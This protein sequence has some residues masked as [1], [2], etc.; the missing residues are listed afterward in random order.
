MVPSSFHPLIR[1]WFAGVYGTPTAI[2]A[3]AWPLIE[4]GEH[5]LAL[6]PTGSGKTLTAFLSAL[7]RF[8]NGRYAADQ[9]GV[10]YV[11]PLKALNEDIRRNLLE[12]IAGIRSR[13]EAAG[14]SFPAI[15]VETRSGDTPQA[16]RRR[17][18]LHPP[19]ILAATP[20]SLAILLLNPR[21]RAVLSSVKY[22]ILDEI[23]TA[24]GTKRGSF[25]SC[26]VDRLALAAGEFQRVALSATV[27]GGESAATLT[28]GLRPLAGG[29]FEGRPVRIAAPASEKRCELTVDFPPDLPASPESDEAGSFSRRYDVLA[30]YIIGRINGSRKTDGDSGVSRPFSTTLVF[31]DSRRRAE[32]LALLLNGKAGCRIAFAHHGSLSRELR[33]DVERRLAE[34]SLPCVV[35]TSSLELGI[36]IG[37]VDEVILAGSPSSASAALQRVGRSGHGAG[38]VSRGVLIP[39]HG[40][41]LLLA[42]ALSLAVHEKEIE[43]PRPVENPLDV[44]AQ[45]VLALCAEKERDAGELYHTVRGFYVFRNLS[46]SSFDSVLRMLAGQGGKKAGGSFIPLRELKPRL[47]LDRLSG[48]LTPAPGLLPL[49]FTSGGVITGRGNYSLRIPGGGGAMIKIGELDEEFVWERRVGDCFDF[50]SRSWRITAIGS[51]AVEALPRSEAANQ[52]P[53]WRAE[54][55]FRSPVLT[56]RLLA[57]LDAYNRTVELPGLPGFSAAAV[58]SLKAYLDSQKAA[59][60]GVPL[61]G[62][63]SIVIEIVSDKPAGRSAA[64]FSD[65]ALCTVLLHT[66]RGSAVN[67]PLRL[68]LAEDLEHT[69]SRRLESF[70]DDNALLLLMP[71][72][73]GPET[74]IRESLA[75]MSESGGAVTRGETLL[76]KRL[77]SSGLFGA[78]FRE[79]AERSLVLPRSPL[80]RR[81]PLWITRQK[82]KRLFDAAA[83]EDDFPVSAEAWR[84][85]LV[86]LFD[87]EAFRNLIDELA[88]GS[89][90]IRC[91]ESSRP[92]PFARDLVRQETNALIYEDDERKDRGGTGGTPSLSD[93]AIAEALGDPSLRPRLASSLVRDFTARLRRELNGWTAEDENGLAEWVK[94]R[95]AIPLDEW[96]LLLAAL[97]PELARTAASDPSL[98][99][100]LLRIERSS[101]EGPAAL[102]IHREWEAAW[103]EEAL[104]LLG[105]WLRY[106]GPL[107]LSRIAAVFGVS[108]AEAEDAVD[109]LV[110]AEAAAR[111]IAV[112]GAEPHVF[113]GDDLAGDRE[114][115][116]LLLRLSR[117]KARPRPRERPAALLVPFLALRQGLCVRETAEQSG[118]TNKPWKAL[119]GFSAPVRLWESEIFPSRFSGYTPR[120]LDGELRDG[121]CVFYGTGKERAAFCAPD[122]LDLVSTGGARDEVFAGISDRH[123]FDR[124]RDFWEIKE[125]LAASS[126]VSDNRTA[127]ASLWE[128]VWEGRLSADSWEALR[129]GAVH[130]F[131]PDEAEE[132]RAPDGSAPPGYPFGQTRRRIPRALRNRWKEGAPVRGNWFSLTGDYPPDESPLDAEELNRGR[133]RLLIERWGILCGP[134]LER[135]APLL[136][137]ARLLPT[138]RRMELAGELAA[139]R[140]FG[141]IN[142]LQFAP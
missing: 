140:F 59:Q 5:V 102:I 13:F 132:T 103:R 83:K 38:R 136:S 139:G 111:H 3:S 94:E 43:A 79:A 96:E 119:A 118:E 56:R 65:G 52:V 109:A 110:E 76:R 37:G 85:C 98:G 20:E 11:S 92:S 90:S 16:E 55:P 22:V 66:F 131:V 97:P 62:S 121:S 41:D 7:S 64:A 129:R 108:E 112:S 30:A 50:G 26:Q 25:L 68:A 142:S 1:E 114:N 27:S 53:F 15:R 29:S 54:S 130:G 8:A 36:D 44:L 23:H 125:A 99:N 116:D 122:D 134:L 4:A 101:A 73:A 32:R 95:I 141:G 63:A 78:A 106:E 127:A 115:L 100:K 93:R 77:E 6:A 34:G 40:M 81:M 105:A 49:L 135:E 89:V 61:A 28:G 19:S 35:A 113:T 17:F 104:S 72:G 75:A 133:V 18:L 69:L 87:M 57:I 86:D 48:K 33:Q 126:G 70:Q 107:P 84:S 138:I 12:P 39:F 88:D 21:G 10:L 71:C 82:S 124:P 117:K 42:A 123:F 51:E 67:Y 9:L 137:W 14:L 47:Y 120:L 91:F 2:Q 58:S 45:I 46:R 128:A 74:L 80:G 60:R 24:L 31:T